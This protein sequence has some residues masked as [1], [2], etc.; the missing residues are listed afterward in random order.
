MQE[1]EQAIQALADRLERLGAPLSLPEDWIILCDDDDLRHMPRT[2]AKRLLAKAKKE[3]ARRWLY[4]R[5]DPSDMD[6]ELFENSECVTALRSL[7]RV[8]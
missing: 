4:V 6:W 5:F 7:T 8:N 2:M 3:T 1:T